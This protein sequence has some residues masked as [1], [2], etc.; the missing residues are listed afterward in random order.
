MLKV[1]EKLLGMLKDR[2]SSHSFSAHF[3]IPLEGEP[4]P[5]AESS[6]LV[7][8]IREAEQRGYSRHCFTETQFSFSSKAYTSGHLACIKEREK[9]PAIITSEWV[10]PPQED[11]VYRL[12]IVQH[13]EPA[14]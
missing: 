8:I 9:Y 3:G 7:E 2:K 6:S 1:N 12:Y 13:K 11:I 14:S 5:V 10:N 4:A